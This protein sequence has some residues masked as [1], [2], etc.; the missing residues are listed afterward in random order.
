[1]T[2]IAE[3]LQ[4]HPVVLKVI[5]VALL[6]H[7]LSGLVYLIPKVVFSRPLPLRPE[8]LFGPLM[9]PFFP[10]LEL[11]RPPWWRKQWLERSE[12]TEGS[13]VLEEGFG[14]GTSPMIAAR[15]VGPKGK[16][17]A[18]DVMPT[19]VATLWLRAKLYRLRNLEVTLADARN[20]GLPER[21]IDVVFIAD[22]FH[23]FPDK[24]GTLTELHRILR[25]DGVLSILEDTQGYAKKAAALAKESG[26]FSLV[27]QDGKFRKFQKAATMHLPETSVT[28]EGWAAKVGRPSRSSG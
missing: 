25:E 4:A 22:A 12:V 24:Q 6:I 5:G 8:Y 7:G 23:E 18:L 14:F 10:L 26:L 2:Q 1:M 19:N 20:T 9:A 11:M 13:V 28:E 3:F 15:M 21:S 16:V 27:E 17:Y